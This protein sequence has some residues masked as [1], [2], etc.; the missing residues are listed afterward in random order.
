MMEEC[1]QRFVRRDRCPLVQL[2][3]KELGT[4]DVRQAMNRASGYRAGTVAA[5]DQQELMDR[6][7]S[8]H[9]L[10]ESRRAALAAALDHHLTLIQG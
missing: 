8:E 5:T 10:N 1:L 9:E 3:A 7:A 4:P 6:I 2:V